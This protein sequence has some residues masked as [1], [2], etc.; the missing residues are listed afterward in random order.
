MLEYYL[1]FGPRSFG[2]GDAQA[3]PALYRIY[4]RQPTTTTYTYVT[5]FE[6]LWRMICR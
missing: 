6:K 5:T 3:R 1:S 4:I 2:P